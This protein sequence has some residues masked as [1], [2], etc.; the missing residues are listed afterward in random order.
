MRYFCRG[1]MVAVERII[2]HK[3][4]LC[5]CKTACITHDAQ[6]AFIMHTTNMF[7]APNDVVRNEQYHRAVADNNRT[8]R[9]GIISY[10]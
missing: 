3:I 8:R 5:S 1:D 9:L 10:E 2:R 4:L 7:L 6:C